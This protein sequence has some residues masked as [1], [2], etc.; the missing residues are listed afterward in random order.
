[1]IVKVLKDWQAKLPGGISGLS[2]IA[3]G[4]DLIFAEAC[5]ELGIPVR[6]LLPLPPFCVASAIVCICVVLLRQ[7]AALK[8]FTHMIYADESRQ[9]QRVTVPSQLCRYYYGKCCFIAVF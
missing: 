4:G 6:V 2:S 1:M 5:F 8:Q 9:S 3:D 7:I